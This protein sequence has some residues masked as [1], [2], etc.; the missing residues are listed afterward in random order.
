MFGWITEVIVLYTSALRLSF[1]SLCKKCW[2]LWPSSVCSLRAVRQ[3]HSFSFV[4]FGL[5]HMWSE[6]KQHPVV[7]LKSLLCELGSV[8]QWSCSF[9]TYTLKGCEVWKSVFA[10]LSFCRLRFNVQSSEP[11][12]KK[13]K[14]RQ[15]QIHSLLKQ[16]IFQ[17]QKSLDPYRKSCE[18][19]WNTNYVW[20]KKVIPR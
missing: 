15:T 20:S 13:S 4:D 16:N 9:C 1:S 14:L 18:L 19:T 6:I 10:A 12:K 2:L 7:Q 5:L 11:K 17:R 8:Y 3:K